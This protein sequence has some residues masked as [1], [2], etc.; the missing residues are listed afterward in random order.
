MTTTT[1]QP[2]LEKMEAL[3]DEMS[4]T[5]K[6]LASMATAHGLIDPDTNRHLHAAVD[7]GLTS[8]SIEEILDSLKKVNEGCC[9]EWPFLNLG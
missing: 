4:I 5:I 9:A 8:K 3:I 2:E 1:I 7:G 6:R